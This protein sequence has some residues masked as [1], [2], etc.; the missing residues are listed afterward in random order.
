MTHIPFLFFSLSYLRPNSCLKI[1]VVHTGSIAL[2]NCQ[3]NG[4][5]PIIAIIIG[6]FLKET[7]AKKQ[8][9]YPVG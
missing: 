7:A 4:F 5:L 8:L 6:A 3:C 1:A 9:C 2:L